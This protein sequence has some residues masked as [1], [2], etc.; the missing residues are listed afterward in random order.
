[1]SSLVTFGTSRFRSTPPR[2][3]RLLGRSIDDNNKE[4]RSTPPRE[5]RQVM[6]SC[7]S[8]CSSFDPRPHA[9]GDGGESGHEARH[10]VSIHAPTRGATPSMSNAINPRLF[11]STPP[12]EG[13]RARGCWTRR[14][15]SF[16]PRPHARGDV[17]CSI[18]RGIVC[19][20]DP[21]P[22]ARGDS[23]ARRPSC[24]SS[25]FDPRPHARGDPISQTLMSW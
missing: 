15:S 25:R 22:H 14:T 11:R 9:R 10:G 13:R 24:A 1:M 19:S 8:R 2:E 4:F 18:H 17:F 16:D 5:G 23:P 7:S 3:G 20:F 6:P 21:R 12:R